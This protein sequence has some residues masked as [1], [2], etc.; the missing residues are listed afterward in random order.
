[1]NAV[2]DMAVSK[3]S[4]E[5]FL[6]DN[7]TSFKNE[8][9]NVAI[10]GK[11]VQEEFVLDLV[12]YNLS[13]IE[14]TI[15]VNIVAFD[16]K[17]Q[18][19]DGVKPYLFSL[20]IR[21]DTKGPVI[22]AISPYPGARLF[23]GETQYIKWSVADESML[24]SATLTKASEVVYAWNDN[25]K[26]AQLAYTVNLPASGGSV[27][28]TVSAEDVYGNKSTFSW[29]YYL[30]DDEPP[31]VSIIAPSPGTRL[32]EGEQFTLSAV[33]TDNRV[34]NNVL[35]F[36]EE[37][38]NRTKLRE[39][40]NA[41]YYDEAQFKSGK[42]FVFDVRAPHRPDNSGAQVNIEVV[43]TDNSGNVTTKSQQL[44]I[45]DDRNPPSVSINKPA[46]DMLL[47]IGAGIEVEGESEDDIYVDRISVIAENT[48]GVKQESDLSN[49]SRTDSV[50]VTEVPNPLSFGTM[51]VAR[52]QFASFKGYFLPPKDL[53][54]PGEK[55]KFFVRVYDRGIN[56]ADSQ[57]IGY[58]LKP[59][60]DKPI[61]TF[62]EPKNIVYEQQPV[63]L[64]VD[65]SDDSSIAS[66]KVYFDKDSSIIAQGGSTEK[67]NFIISENIDISG[68]NP[69]D[70]DKNYFTV[71]ANATDVY[72]NIAESSYTVVVRKDISPSF[73][74]VP[75]S[76]SGA[77]I[78]QVL[79]GAVSYQQIYVVD[80][81]D[82]EIQPLFYFPVYTSLSDPGSD[83]GRNA[84]GFPITYNSES[85]DMFVQVGY[86]EGAQLPG[87]VEI[88]GDTYIETTPEGK[89]KVF[90]ST[91]ERY[92]SDGYLKVDFGSGYKVKYDVE[93]HSSNICDSQTRKF[94]VEDQK[95]IPYYDV[96]VEGVSWTEIIPHVYDDAD[97]IVDVYINKIIID[98]NNQGTP[99][100]TVFIYENVNGV[101]MDA[102]IASGSMSRNIRGDQQ[103]IKTKIPIHPSKDFEK[104]SVLVYGMDRF[105]LRILKHF[106]LFL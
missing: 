105:S 43:A 20:D 46:K 16:S 62:R 10:T 66:Y 22:S 97:E 59:D 32:I 84:T 60:Q 5:Y 88:N 13:N 89:L 53:C 27:P 9:K 74:V 61:I 85:A 75:V 104:L 106:H 30:D 42:P 93:I 1:V 57:K 82:T 90:P 101:K 31:K 29:E 86:I 54:E 8:T 11:N 6:D 94:T 47:K 56:Q 71:V 44:D 70:P 99:I 68:L 102:F 73:K 41:Q 40:K 35:F 21:P 2:D 79:K 14:H 24:K 19:S 67:S 96:A 98:S 34:L 3:I 12:P 36:F 25:V 64:T 63:T 48:K 72:G 55:C 18:K 28:F 76:S 103:S 51:I 38:G 78:N 4:V 83:T 33:V 37:S 26:S 49:L 23:K 92:V 39:F 77:A 95:G 91:A 80:D 17:E 69:D 45:L 52:R 7:S 81:Y 87:T 50:K 100:V 65:I 58:E 15:K